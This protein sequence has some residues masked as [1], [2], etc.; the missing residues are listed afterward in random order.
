MPPSILAARPQTSDSCKKGIPNL[1]PSTHT[2]P[3]TISNFAYSLT[4]N[5]TSPSMKTLAS[6][7]LLRWKMTILSILSTTHIDNVPFHFLGECTFF[8]T[9][10]WKGWTKSFFLILHCV[11]Y[12]S[13]SAASAVARNLIWTT[14]ARSSS[15]CI[16]ICGSEMTPIFTLGTSFRIKFLHGLPRQLTGKGMWSSVEFRV[17][18]EISQVHGCHASDHILDLGNQILKFT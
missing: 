6:H 18:E 5:F 15:L 11:V 10:E 7:S 1:N 12:L 2:L 3:I 4:K 17:L 16:L 14:G 8:G 9:G 13:K